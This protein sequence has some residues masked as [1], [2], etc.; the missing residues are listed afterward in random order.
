MYYGPFATSEDV[1]IISNQGERYVPLVDPY[2]AAVH[3]GHM[4]SYR[5]ALRYAYGKKIL[6]LGCGVG[7][8]SHFLASFGA[9][10]VTAAD[11]DSIAIEY[12]SKTYA[13]PSIQYV[14]FDATKPLP[15]PDQSFD[16]VF[17]SQVIEHVE[18][19]FSFLKEIRRVLIYGNFCLITTPNKEL[20]NPDPKTTPNKHHLSEMNFSEFEALGRRVFAKVKVNGIPQNCVLYNANKTLDLKINE[21]IV[22]EDYLMRTDNVSTCENLLMFAHTKASGKFEETLPS[23]LMEVAES[24][25]PYFW[26]PTV[27]RWVILSKYPKTPIQG[28]VEFKPA[29]GKA[30][31]VFNSPYDN[32]YRVDIGLLNRG[33][34][35]IDIVLHKGATQRTPVMY[36]TVIAQAG[37]KL[38]II[39]PPVKNSKGHE[40][41]LE[42]K[43]RYSIIN[44]FTDRKNLPRF[45]FRDGELPLWTFHQLEV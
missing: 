1:S 15:F 23:S 35:N 25:S 9:A 21:D 31:T 32:L 6:D 44:R 10:E 2:S 20:F 38:S 39:F 43:G 29:I 14:H 13:H 34:F 36:H 41:F 30:I 4:A 40:F 17:C 5:Y 16:F 42:L 27:K 19:P 3:M 11:A 12:A 24:L 45:E 37:K 28:K 22:P 18:D 7:Y 33:R 8:G 26:D